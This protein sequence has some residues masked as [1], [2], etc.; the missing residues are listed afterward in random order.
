MLT[1][2][3]QEKLLLRSEWRELSKYQMFEDYLRVRDA[4]GLKQLKREQ[5]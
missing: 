5:T 3:Q 1:L 4:N 2:D